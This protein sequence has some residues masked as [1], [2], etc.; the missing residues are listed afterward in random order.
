MRSMTRPG[1]ALAAVF[2]TAAA[3]LGVTAPTVHAETA[4]PT[5]QAE[6]AAPSACF[7]ATTWLRVRTRPNN[8]SPV[9]RNLAPGEKVQ[10]SLR[11]TN[12]F[13]MLWNNPNRW[14]G[15]AYLVRC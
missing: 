9:V 10:A 1:V 2:L 14:A 11:V 4:T 3:S 8:Q 15:A 13:R 6:A 12:G 7:K 5:A